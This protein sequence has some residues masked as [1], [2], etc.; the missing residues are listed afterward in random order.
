MMTV[1]RTC[2]SG[3][4]HLPGCVLA[5]LRSSPARPARHPSPDPTGPLRPGARGLCSASTLAST[6]AHRGG[7]HDFGSVVD[8]LRG[9]RSLA[10][11]HRLGREL[12]DRQVAL[13]LV[14]RRQ[15]LHL[16]LVGVAQPL[17]E[18]VTTRVEHTAGRWVGGARDLTGQRDPLAGYRRRR[19]ARRT[20]APRC[21]DG[22]APRR[23][24][25]WCRVRRSDRR[26]SRRSGRRGTGRR[27]CRG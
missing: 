2:S 22:S 23:S 4:S 27:R 17:D 9:N 7:A 11:D 5:T 8:D 26:T 15:F 24:G 25:R 3:R 6:T 19:S 18:A 14:T 21:T 10:D 1:L 16:R 20:A 13:D 12:L